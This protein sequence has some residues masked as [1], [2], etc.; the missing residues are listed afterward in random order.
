MRAYLYCPVSRIAHNELFCIKAL[1]DDNGIIREYY[2]SDLVFH[3]RLLNNSWSPAL[4]RVQ[5]PLSFPVL[6]DP[7]SRQACS[8]PGALPPAVLW[9]QEPA[10]LPLRPLP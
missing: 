8:R 7:V 2:L 10:S 9:E 3:R 5:L 4:I 6:S 1:V